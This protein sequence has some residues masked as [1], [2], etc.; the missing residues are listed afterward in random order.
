[1]QKVILLSRVSTGLQDLEQQTEQLIKYAKSIGYSESDFIILEDKESAVKLSEEE[2][3]GLNRLKENILQQPVKDVVVYELSRIARVPKILYSIRDFLLKHKVQLHI[4][5]PMIKLLKDDGTLD[6]SA[7]VIFS[8]FCSLSENEGFLRQQ[9][10]KRGRARLA[11]E[12]K[13][14]GGKLPYGY[15]VNKNKEFVILEEER[16]IVVRI[17]EEYKT[18]TIKDIAKDLLFEGVIPATNLNAAQGFV[19]GILHRD[20]YTGIKT[21]YNGQVKKNYAVQYP[22]IISD[23]DFKEAQV[24]LKE[25]KHTCKTKSKYNYLCRGIVR[26]ING[27]QLRPQHSHGCYAYWRTN[28]YN[29]ETL[30]IKVRLLDDIV[31]H[32]ALE[33]KKKKPGKDLMKYKLELQEQLKVISKKV[34]T[35]KKKM[36]EEQ[37][38]ILK[39]EMRYASGKMSE[40]VL[41]LLVGKV[42]QEMK[43][44]EAEHHNLEAEGKDLVSRMNNISES[45]KLPLLGTLSEEDKERIVHEEVERV[46]VIKGKRKSDYTL[47]V[48]FFTGDYVMV[49]VNS[50][51]KRVWGEDG[52]EVAYK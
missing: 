45:K 15:G 7:N 9:R 31:F 23:S 50:V 41:D 46:V 39:L 14:F 30:S 27:D 1:M 10:F 16:D 4:L 33:N 12:N 8:L 6:E 47:G 3:N 19:R 48:Q 38:K 40:E 18:R 26:T 34:S 37:D 11:N 36:E 29:W 49:D 20:A 17:F 13:Y 28:K 52:V 22:R 21:D 51:S 5:N 42:Q 44:Y 24:K 43:R 2:R 35:I 32:F 25:R